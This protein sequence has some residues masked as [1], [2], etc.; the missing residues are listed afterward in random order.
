MIAGSV[1]GVTTSFK[2]G[3]GCRYTV[4]P[5]LQTGTGTPPATMADGRTPGGFMLRSHESVTFE[6]SHGWSGRLWG[7]SRCNFTS[8]GVGKCQTGDCGGKLD[9]GGIGATPPVTLIELTLQGLRSTKDFYDVSLVDGYNLPITLA[10]SGLHI[11]A[12][13]TSC[14]VAGCL[15][16]LNGHCPLDL[17]VSH[18]YFVLSIV[19]KINFGDFFSNFPFLLSLAKASF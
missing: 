18:F 2:M 5:A 3:N 12:N 15:S 13:K 6:V 8:D 11:T 19:C 17:Q 1:E 9:C 16:D 7:R 10:P 14:G 4:W